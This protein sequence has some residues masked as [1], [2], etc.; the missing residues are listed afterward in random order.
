[1]EKISMTSTPLYPNKPNDDSRTATGSKGQSSQQPNAKAP[2]GSDSRDEGARSFRSVPETAAASSTRVGGSSEVLGY[3]NSIEEFAG[4]ARK[5]LST[6]SRDGT[7]Q[8][9]ERQTNEGGPRASHT[10]DA[11]QRDARQG[12]D[13]Q[14]SD[15]QGN[16]N[17]PTQV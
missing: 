9:T 11:E 1:L 8:A 4:K 3:L 5:A 6:S 7:S 15:R 2:Q 14:A 12:N 16:R 17:N 13:R 10:E